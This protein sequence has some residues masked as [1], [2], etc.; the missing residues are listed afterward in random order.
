MRA[1]EF[2]GG[3]ATGGALISGRMAART[4]SL[5]VGATRAMVAIESLLGAAPLRIVRSGA[6]MRAP[7]GGAGTPGV[8]DT[9]GAAENSARRVA[10]GITGARSAGLSPTTA[11][12]RL[13]AV[14]R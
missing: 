3:T 13:G 12:V 4:L 10:S 9:S 14:S 5:D 7:S 6:V 8:R 11:A 1:V 2:A